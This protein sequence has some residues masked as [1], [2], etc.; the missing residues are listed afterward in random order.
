M[1]I[2]CGIFYLICCSAMASAQAIIKGRIT[3]LGDA[4]V[5]LYKYIN[6]FYSANTFAEYDA[7][8]PDAKGRFQQKIAVSTPCMMLLQIGELPVNIF[9]EP[10]ASV[11]LDIDGNKFNQKDILQ[12]IQFKGYNAAGNQLFFALNNQPGK[13]IMTYNKMIDSSGFRKSRDLAQL[14]AVLNKMLAPFDSLRDSQLI[15]AGFYAIVV[16][17]LRHL[18][19]AVEASHWMTA[20]WATQKDSALALLGRIYSRYPDNTSVMKNS[21]FSSNIMFGRYWYRAAVYHKTPRYKDSSIVMN[22]TNYFVNSNLLRWL[23]A[24]ISIREVGWALS[25]ISLKQLFAD[26]YGQRDI[27]TYKAFFPNGVMLKYLQPPYFAL[28]NPVS[29]PA[30]SALIKILNMGLTDRLQDLIGKQYKGKYVFVDFWAS[31]CIPCKQE[32]AYNAKLDS[33]FAKNNIER[34]YISL[35]QVS[36]RG[37][38]LKNIYQYNLKGNHVLV[39]DTFFN[40][41]KARFSK[42]GQFPIPRYMLFDK[43]GNLL[44]DDAPRPSTAG[45]NDKIS[46]LTV[47]RAN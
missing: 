7:I 6:G 14:D 13:K 23:H 10:G 5:L 17:G 47:V 24:P 31:W 19:L 37:A 18:F 40:D 45:F 35:D 1:K 9:V 44:S 34:L 36:L 26:S 25:L 41:I 15:T 32:F 43:N 12:A 3:Q 39:N 8:V 28:D 20:G 33:F 11:E 27:D 21:V 38:F 29:M 30:D 22:N 2:I 46:K 16:E 4:K 42:D